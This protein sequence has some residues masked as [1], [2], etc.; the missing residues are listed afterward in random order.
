MVSVHWG[1]RSY[2]SDNDFP[3]TVHESRITHRTNPTVVRSSWL[4][5]Y[6]Y[7]LLGSPFIHQNLPR[8]VTPTSLP[9]HSNVPSF[10]RP[11][12]DCAVFWPIPRAC[13]WQPG[14][15]YWSDVAAGSQYVT[16]RLL[17]WWCVSSTSH[18]AAASTISA[19]QS[20]T[21]KRDVTWK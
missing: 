20:R 1:F 21:H 6:G 4:L 9:G 19:D 13:L 18:S 2:P 5:R 14:D 17:W 8:C 12:L 10:P 3:L 16:S 15:G 11:I 7:A